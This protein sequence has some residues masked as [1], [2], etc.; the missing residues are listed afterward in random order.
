MNFNDYQQKAQTS[1]IYDE[2][3]KVI[4]PMIGLTSEVGE[5]ADK[6]KKNMRDGNTYSKEDI[7]KEMGDVLWYLS[8]LASDMDISLESIAETNLQKLRKRQQEGKISGSG[9]E[10]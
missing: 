3:H 5:V 2:K 8:T 4:Y 10:R 1:A 9:D 6:I 7:A